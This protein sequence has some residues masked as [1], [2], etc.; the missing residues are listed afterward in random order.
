M[1]Q[2]PEEIIITNENN[3][4]YETICC[5]ICLDEYKNEDKILKY[6]CDHI[7]HKKCIE[8]W[9]KIEVDNKNTPSCPCCRNPIKNTNET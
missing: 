8:T 3:T 7:F 1:L 5:S 6:P 2:K 9:I 4:E